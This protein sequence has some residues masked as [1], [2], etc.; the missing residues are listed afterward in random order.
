MNILIH[1]QVLVVLVATHWDNVE[2]GKYEKIVGEAAQC[3][4]ETIPKDIMY[5]EV[6]FIEDFLMKISSQWDPLN[7]HDYLMWPANDGPEDWA[8][9][10]H[11]SSA[12]KQCLEPAF[13][14]GINLSLN[15]T[16]QEIA[17]I[18]PSLYFLT[19][20]EHQDPKT[21]N[22]ECVHQRML[23]DDVMRCLGI[24]S[25]NQGNLNFMLNINYPHPM[26]RWFR[27]LLFCSD[28]S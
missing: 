2:A 7:P 28:M 5:G 1:I 10:C 14:Y 20:C 18:A 12:I 25:W 27:D 8:A 15:V 19:L 11:F 9:R 3:V 23:S 17:I 4:K 22:A 16:S 13:K 21:N 6:Q 24:L 26:Y